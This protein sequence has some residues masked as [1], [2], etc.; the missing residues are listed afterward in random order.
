MAFVKAHGLEMAA[1]GY[2]KNMVIETFTDA[3]EPTPTE[4]GRCWYNSDDD[5]WVMSVDNGSGSIIKRTFANLE[6]L[7]AFQTLLVSTTEGEGANNV[8]YEGS[9]VQTNGLFALSA[10]LLDDV[11]DNITARI[12]T[13]MKEMDDVQSNKLN[14]SGDQAMTGSLDMD[15]NQIKNLAAGTEAGDAITKSQ[16]D[17]VQTGLDVKESCRT[18][19]TVNLA[20]TY[21]NG[22][23]TITSSSNAHLEMDGVRLDAGNRVLVMNQTNAF[24]NGIYNVTVAGSAGA[25]A[26]VTD[27]TAVADV[28]GSLSGRYFL[29]NSTG[30]EYFVWIDVDNTSTSPDAAGKPLEGLGKTGIQVDINSNDGQN[31]VAT[32]IQGAIDAETDFGASVLAD[33]VTITNAANGEVADAA[34]AENDAF[35]PGFAIA[36]TTQGDEAATAFVL[37]RSADADNQPGS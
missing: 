10:G 8:G 24:E 20:G 1:G 29:L 31:A 19:T 28:S 12:D 25:A 16:L 37:T 30:T 23:G 34:V 17:A 9:G 15:G 6:E 33:V 36:V 11:L 21:N 7:T 14:R 3:T 2:V 26:E 27:V 32:A 35:D 13:E 4:Q 22:A 5:R 18:A